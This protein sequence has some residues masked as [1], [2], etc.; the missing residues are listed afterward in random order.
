MRNG[1]DVQHVVSITDVGHLTSDADEGEDRME[2]GS[3]R[4]GQSAWAIDRR[5]TEA[6]VADWR[7]LRF[8]EPTVRTRP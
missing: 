8:L 4:T 5:Y 3:R 6:F 7:A 1:H 2:K